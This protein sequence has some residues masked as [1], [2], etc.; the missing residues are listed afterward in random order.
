MGLDFFVYSNRVSK[1]YTKYAVTTDKLAE[2]L[3]M[4]KVK[5]FIY[6]IPC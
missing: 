2:S 3:A 1:Q 5:E 4:I 6:T